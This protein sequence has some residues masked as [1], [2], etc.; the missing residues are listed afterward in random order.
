M[1]EYDEYLASALNFVVENGRVVGD[2]PE[3]RL[4]SAVEEVKFEMSE[5]G[6]AEGNIY[7]TEFVNRHYNPN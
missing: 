3:E 4:D 2:T 1:H 5:M 7:A 6:V